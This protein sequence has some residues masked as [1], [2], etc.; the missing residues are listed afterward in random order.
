ME[1]CITEG[2]AMQACRNRTRP[3]FVQN[4]GVWWYFT[5][6]A[7]LHLSEAPWGSTDKLNYAYSGGPKAESR[8]G[9]RT[10][11]LGD[12]VFYHY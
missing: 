6:E 10:A 9:I 11:H 3:V 7:P 4:V 12:A 1:D 8:P 2:Q 5:E